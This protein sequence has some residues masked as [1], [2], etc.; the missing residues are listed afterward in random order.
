MLMHILG[1]IE[2]I[3]NIHSL[4]IDYRDIIHTIRVSNSSLQEG[5]VI[6]KREEWFKLYFNPYLE[7]IVKICR[8]ME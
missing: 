6:L 1:L 7:A 5:R 8:L 2:T 3:D 4:T